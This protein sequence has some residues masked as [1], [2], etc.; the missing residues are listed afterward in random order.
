MQFLTINQTDLNFNAQKI[1]NFVKKSIIA[2]V[3]CNGYG[4]TIPIAVKAWY[5][6]GI[7]FFA[8]SEPHE[9]I[10]IREA[11]YNEVDILLLTP[12]ADEALIKILFENNVIFTVTNKDNAKKIADA[13]FSKAR[14]HLKVNVGM[15]RFG[16]NWTQLNEIL[17]IYQI[18]G[19]K[20]E[21]IFAHF[22]N[23]FEKNYKLTKIQL[24][25]FLEL[26]NKLKNQNIE[27]GLSHIANSAAAL[28]FEETRLDTVRIGSALLGRIQNVPIKLK[29]IGEL[30]AQIVDTLV[31]QKGDTS[32]YAS[33]FKAKKK[34]NCAVVAIGTFHGFGIDKVDDRFRFLDL[35][36]SVYNSLKKFKK[37]LFVNYHSQR[38][39]V[40]GRIG[41][42]F[43]LIDTTKKDVTVSDF[44]CV[45]CNILLINSSIERILED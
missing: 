14:V 9:A 33:I 38:F 42:Q 34:T 11:G 25:R 5:N 15:G 30:K 16:H 40:L 28:R 41:N 8:V 6:A 31:L 32:G 2:V 1:V 23:S 3:K 39:N 10:A 17:Q 21:G 26:T 44:V 20:F 4:L 19:L 12:V 27:I 24:E 45:P 29:K 35:I 18:K 43:T 13:T 37:P 22:S 7:R 36:R